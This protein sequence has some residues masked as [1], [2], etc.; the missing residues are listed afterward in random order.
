LSMSVIQ[1]LLI[2]GST[3]PQIAKNHNI[4]PERLSRLYKPVKKNFKYINLK[5][6]VK[7][8][9]SENM[10]TNIAPFDRIYTWDRLSKSEIEAYNNYNQKHKA[11]YETN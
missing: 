11:Y 6:K 2:K 4:R 5:A 8:N 3:L 9:E 7:A 1:E 10:S